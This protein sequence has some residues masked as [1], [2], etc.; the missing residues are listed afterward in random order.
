MSERLSKKQLKEDHFLE[1]VQS[2]LAYARDNVA[3]VVGGLVVFIAAVVLAVRVGGD[4]S[5]RTGGN[6]EADRAL[7]EA[8]TEFA[9]GRMDTGIAALQAVRSNH[10]GSRAA[11]EAAYVLG[12]AY[13]ESHDWANAQIAFEEF[14][15]KPLYDDL[16]KDGARLAIAACK[17]E[18]G[19]L[20]GAIADY[21]AIWDTGTH[22]GSRIQGAMSAARCSL[23]QGQPDQARELYQAV[24][25]RHPDSPE[26]EDAK[27]E[28]M[29]LGNA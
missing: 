29:A 9:L 6:P 14:L 5:G 1:L 12:N 13:F 24:V 16:M 4:A 23:R 25:D 21:R 27:F 11:K 7:S 28:L 8:R 19:D 17:E 18:S 22:A 10:G 15:S 20:A 2:G 3:I 26:A